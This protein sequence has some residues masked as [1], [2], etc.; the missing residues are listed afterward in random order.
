MPSMSFLCSVPG[1]ETYELVKGV[2]AW[3]SIETELH[4]VLQIGDRMVKVQYDLCGDPKSLLLYLGYKPANAR[5]ACIYRM[6]LKDRWGTCCSDS[7]CATRFVSAPAGIVLP[8]LRPRDP[9]YK[10]PPLVN[11]ERY[12]FVVIDILHM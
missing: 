4:P 1:A 5:D 8:R 12:K 3:E 7:K 10:Q 6:C 9:G 11:V 2:K